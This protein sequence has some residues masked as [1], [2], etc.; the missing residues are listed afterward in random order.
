MQSPFDPC[1]VD[2]KVIFIHVPKSAGTSFKQS[3]YGSSRKLGHR[4]ICEFYSYNP[5]LAK[6]FYKFGV[7]RNPWDRFLSAYT[8][9]RHGKNTSKRDKLF[10]HDVLDKFDGFTDFVESLESYVV[11]RK[12]LS[13]VHFREQLYWICQ[14]GDKTHALDQL[15]RFETL[16]KDVDEFYRTIRRE[17]VVL[18]HVRQSDHASF[19][20][21]YTL[22]TQKI[23]AE[24]YNAD[25][26]LLGY[27]F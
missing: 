11:R 18:P 17:P 1:V 19:R 22:K 14:P 27:E 16:Q 20:E 2:A 6:Q 7:V 12:V 4:R 25:I 10:V 15:G 8:F 13:Y 26:A 23:I 5:A 9:L 24:I 3:L 21:S